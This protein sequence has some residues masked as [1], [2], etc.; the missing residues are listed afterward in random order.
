MIEL[1]WSAAFVGMPYAD[2]GRT[3]DGADC[4]GL[5]RLVYAE[6]LGI[7][8]PAFDGRYAT[9]EARGEIARLISE[10]AAAGDWERVEGRHRPFDLLVFRVG[11]YDSHVGLNVRPGLMLHMAEEDQARV[12]SYACERWAKRFAGAWRHRD[13][14][15]L[16][17]D[18]APKPIL[19]SRSV[20]VSARALVM[21]DG[22]APD[23]ALPP[24]FTIAE[25]VGRALP[26]ATPDML[27]RTEIVLVTPAGRMPVDR[28]HWHRVRP[29]DG[30]L[31][32]IRV[33]PGKGNM[34]KSVLGVVVAIAAIAAGA[35]L[36]P[37]IAGS[38]YG[39]GWSAATWQ[40]L[41]GLGT[42]TLGTLALNALI[43]TPTINERTPK[44]NYLISGWQNAFAPD[45]PVPA[46]L[47]KHRFSPPFAVT[48]YT[49][50]ENGKQFVLAVFNLGYGR[51][52]I[53]DHRIGETPITDFEKYRLQVRDGSSGDGPITLVPD[54]V[55]EEAIGT[56][57]LHNAP[58]RRTLA[59]DCSKA[60]IILL[61]PSGMV[62]I[63]QK[64][65]E[66]E[67]QVGIRI[68][69]REIGT[70]TWTYDETITIRNKTRDPFYVEHDWRLG[71]RSVR[72]EVDVTRLSEDSE[73][74]EK[75]DRVQFVALQSVRPEYWDNFDD[76]LAL[77]AIRIKASNQL[78]GALDSYNCLASRICL[79]WNAGTETWV[80][81]ET[82]NPASLSRWVL[83]GAANAKGYSN[84]EIDLETLQDWHEF[85]DDKGLSYDRIHD[86]EGSIEDALVAI[87][88]AGRASP[89]FD[90][91]KWS[92][93]IDRPKIIV[94]DQ[95]NARNS[96]SF[97]WDT[98]YGDPPHALRV[99]FLDRT[100]GY[101]SAERIVPWPG[102]TG[103]ITITEQL[104]LPGKTDPD[105]IWIE[106]RRRMHEARYRTTTYQLITDSVTRPAVRGDLVML[107]QD[108]LARLTKAA[109]VVA[110]SGMTVALDDVIEMVDGTTHA[111]RWRWYAD[112]GDAVGESTVRQ[113]YTVPG[114]SWAVTIST[115]DRVPVAGDIVHFGP[116]ATESLPVIV[117]S[118]EAGENMTSVYT[119]IA[120]SDLIDADT[121]AEVP[122]AWSGRVGSELEG[123]PTEPYAPVIERVLTGRTG[124]GEAG[125]LEVRVVP[126]PDEDVDIKSYDIDHREFGDVSWTTVTLAA[127]AGG[128]DISGYASGD[129]VQIRARAK[130][131]D[132]DYG[133]YS[134]VTTVTIGSDD[135][136]EPAALPED[137][138]AVTGGLGWALIEGATGDDDATVRIQIY[139][140]ASSDPG[141]LD[142]VADAVGDPFDVGLEAAW[143]YT[144]GDPSRKNLLRNPAFSSSKGWTTGGGWSI[145]D[146]VAVHAP[147]SGGSVSR[148]V[149][150][151]SGKTYR[152]SVDVD[153]RTAGDVTPRLTGGT[154]VDGAAISA[155][156][157]ALGS[158]V[159]V[160]GNDTFSVLASSD[161]DGEIDDLVVYRQT[162]ACIDQGTWYYWAEPQNGSGRP[163]PM[164]GPFA[165]I[166]I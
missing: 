1:D 75:I 150:L 44:P 116:L 127:S 78:T 80:Q 166:I 7:E 16:A 159:A 99:P 111:I 141:A 94:A 142:R 109:R 17:I 45:A 66:R 133:P 65:D 139:R 160:G 11:R 5:V 31:V 102:Y 59:R 106:A 26:G 56:E 144:D 53:S 98:A 91:T 101:Q 100:N 128:K 96:R 69:A 37:L 161:F 97:R 20:S 62:R 42:I 15:T 119:L 13:A 137:S 54:Q 22:A 124:T 52:A 164:A 79:D 112:A 24:G 88:A 33:I 108:V 93:V 9:T 4:W 55:I 47:G 50:I 153:A 27:E 165:T 132:N 118:I 85:C 71:S 113:V 158:V 74:P 149:T 3:R 121:D 38:A 145:G 89:R 32:D 82:R 162:A 146:G 58:I 129:V 87:A 61:F 134:D 60:R 29:R 40:S 92:W 21:P 43:P 136:T 107:N 114:D 95:F 51:L 154:A 39:F 138:I 123:L 163:G 103:D 122:P 126:N 2:L 83:Q 57:L 63:E 68:R 115:G 46:V 152:I 49:R 18:A 28:G 104:D 156:G 135:G 81:R 130:S 151:V 70:G 8:L 73:K 148:A 10:Q 34:L 105:E 117:K 90:G 86:F 77:V 12:D 30:V 6:K 14:G 48:P 76:D 64:G 157:Q 125:G 19:P 35:Y 67:I 120:T 72:Y 41:I 84:S 143:S 110:V 155:N 147:G 36:G 140:T 23:I 131:I 25:I